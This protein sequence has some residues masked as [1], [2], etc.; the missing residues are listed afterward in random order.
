M[1]LILIMII[2]NLTRLRVNTNITI[3]S[4]YTMAVD[5]IYAICF[6]NA[7]IIPLYNAIATIAGIGKALPHR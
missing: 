7:S 2:K 5:V 4:N 3:N 1:L 6:A